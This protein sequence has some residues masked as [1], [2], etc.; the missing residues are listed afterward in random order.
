MYA[1]VEKFR[2]LEAMLVQWLD[3]SNEFSI[4]FQPL[5]TLKPVW[6]D[7]ELLLKVLQVIRDPCNAWW[8]SQ[9][10]VNKI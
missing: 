5:Y 2:S 3:Y 6:N 8:S 4:N 7:A 1:I 10:D 9:N